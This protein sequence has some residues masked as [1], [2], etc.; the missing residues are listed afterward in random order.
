MTSRSYSGALDD[1]LRPL[2]FQRNGDDWV[3]VRGDIREWVNRQS[4]RLGV[5]LNLQVADIETN[6]LFADIFREEGL[7]ELFRPYVRIGQII[8]RHDRW[9]RSDQPGGPQD[10]IEALITDGLP[11]LDKTRTLEQQAEDWYARSAYLNVRSYNANSLIGLALTLYRM[12]EIQ[13]ACEVLR[14]PVTRRAIPSGVAKVAKLRE[15]L[16]CRAG[17]AIDKGQA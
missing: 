7:L 16:G 4:G 10:M 11:W 9:W 12:G 6:R 15:W 2:G 17:P 13:E 8:D 14:K 1:A 3:R 5:T